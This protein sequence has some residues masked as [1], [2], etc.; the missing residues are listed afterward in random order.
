MSDELVQR[1]SGRDTAQWLRAE[2]CK[3]LE[4]EDVYIRCRASSPRASWRSSP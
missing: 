2:I 1:W 3:P 4:V